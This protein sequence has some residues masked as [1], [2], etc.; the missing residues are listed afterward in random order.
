MS[1]AQDE[2]EKKERHWKNY[3]NFTLNQ[4]L[5]LCDSLITKVIRMKFSCLKHSFRNSI[6]RNRT[7]NAH[8]VTIDAALIKL[9]AI[10]FELILDLLKILQIYK[11]GQIE[12]SQ[13]IHPCR[14][15]G[16]ITIQ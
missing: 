5:S 3:N 9:T 15:G 11:R 7:D 16:K 1:M 14:F 12:W 4:N 10:D 2:G 8:S 6:Y 13:T